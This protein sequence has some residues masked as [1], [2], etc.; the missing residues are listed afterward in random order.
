MSWNC[1][2]ELCRRAYTGKLY[3]SGWLDLLHHRDGVVLRAIYDDEL[4]VY[5]TKLDREILVSTGDE[6]EYKTLS[7]TWEEEV[8]LIEFLQGCEV[9]PVE[10]YRTP[11]EHVLRER[12]SS[13]S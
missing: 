11:F 2:C 8:A 10:G 6:D 7:E 5:L 1:H 9:E 13:T 3:D 12:V 4:T